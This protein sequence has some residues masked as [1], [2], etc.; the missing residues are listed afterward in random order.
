MKKNTDTYTHRHTHTHV[1]THTRTHASPK[2]PIRLN[3]IHAALQRLVRDQRDVVRNDNLKRLAVQLQQQLASSSSVVLALELRAGSKG[4]EVGAGA[5]EF[6][7]GGFEGLARAFEVTC[8]GMRMVKVVVVMMMM[9]MMM[10]TTLTIPIAHSPVCSCAS[11]KFS[12]KNCC[13]GC[14]S[15]TCLNICSASE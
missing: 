7:N 8:V 4:A 14:I 2:L 3:L 15:H 13:S 5:A 1:H 12:Q 11:A 9:M 10:M 6:A